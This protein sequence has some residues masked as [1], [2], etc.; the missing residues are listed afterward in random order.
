M[1]EGARHSILLRIADFSSIDTRRNLG[2]TVALLVITA[3]TAAIHFYQTATYALPSGQFKNLHVG[4]SLLI[5]YLSFAE[6]SVSKLR[7][8]ACL[9]LALICVVPLFYIHLQFDQLTSDRMFELTR[10]DFLISIILLSTTLLAVG[11]QW[12]KTIPIIVIASVLY[13]R[14]GAYLP[15]E[16]FFHSGIGTGRLLSYTSIPLFQGILGSLT[17]LSAG[18]VFVLMM[19][20]GLLKST[21]G[22]DFIWTVGRAVS[23]RSKAGPAQVAVFCSGFMGMI[24][25]STVANVASTGSMTI[26]MMKKFGYRA[27]HAAAIEAVASTGGQFAPPV[28]GLTA[29]LIV[30]MTG[31]PYSEIMLAAAFPALV[32][33]GYLIAAINIQSRLDL[34]HDAIANVQ[35][36]L[37]TDTSFTGNVLKEYGHL[38]VSIVVLVWYLAGQTPPAFAATYAMAVIAVTEIG[39]QVWKARQE[40]RNGLIAAARILFKGLDDGVRMGAQLAIVIAAIS[41]FVDVLVT[42]GFAQKLSYLMLD[43]AAEQLWLMLGMTALACLVFGLGM[44][45]P[46]A[47]ILVALLG[48]PALERIG[49]PELSAHMFVFYFANMSAITPPVAVAVLVAAKIADSGYFRTTLRACRLGLAGFVLPFV[50]VYAP[51]IL[52][53]DSSIAEGL[54]A[55]CATLLA[56]VSLNAAYAGVLR[57]PLSIIERLLLA[58]AGVMI[59]QFQ[60]LA[61]AIA[62][63]VVSAVYLRQLWKD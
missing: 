48:V 63:A 27:E 45:T 39:K 35:Q 53:I 54:I 52:L 5:V 1:N 50:F 10:W 56:L 7:G 22:I 26:P 14:F 57:K 6:S 43:I 25:G 34:A 41:V 37:T 23:G 40:P 42:T 21:G 38:L 59:F 19:F 17:S 4:L 28:M 13:A 33:Y 47:Y 9:S 29:F 30:G 60:M 18:T 16:L 36:N 3:L 12:G 44:P 8:I 11:M 31:I 51:A 61:F 20:V 32:Y 62:A 55:F 46:A 2:Y 15:G 49:V 58:G 24:S